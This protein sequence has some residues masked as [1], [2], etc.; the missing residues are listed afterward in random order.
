LTE[1]DQQKSNVTKSY[2]VAAL[3]ILI[4]FL[5]AAWYANTQ[6]ESHFQSRLNDIQLLQL[7]KQQL[8]QQEAERK[9]ELA[10]DL[11][12]ADPT[13][14]Q[15]L[16]QA[17]ERY[18][19]QGPK[20]DLSAIRQ[21]L[22]P[23]LNGYW[24]KVTLYGAS[25][26]HLHLA[27][28]AF[29]LLRAHRPERHSDSLIN[30]R[31]LVMH[32][33]TSGT[34]VTGTELGRHGLSL[35]A[36]VPVF[37]SRHEV[38]AA[39]ELGFD[40]QSVFAARQQ[41]YAASGVSTDNLVKE[42]RQST[43]LLVKPTMTIALHDD[44]KA[45]WLTSRLWHSPTQSDMLQFWLN[46]QLIPENVSSP[47][48]LIL[49]FNERIYA[50]SLLPWPVWGQNN[51][52]NGQVVSLSWHDISAQVNTQQ[53]TDKIIWL[54]WLAACFSMLFLAVLLITFLRR[55]ARREVSQQQKLVKQS[56]Q[57]LS[58][59][60]Q[61]SPLPILLNRFSD[62]AFVESNPAME[63]LTGYSLAEIKQL[64]YWDLTPEH[65]AAAEQE[66]LK[67]LTEYGRYGPYIKQYRHK[68]GELIDIE[69]N[70]VLFSDDR[71]EKFIWTIIKDIREIK[72]IEKLK[73]D[74]VSTVSHELRTPLTSISGSLGLVLGGAGG[75]LSPK[76]EKL[77]GIAHK[78]SQRL[79][80]LINDL[81]DIEKLVAGKMRFDEV[82]VALPGILQDA[83]EQHQ[84][85]AQQHNVTLTLNPVPDVLLW[86][87]AARVQQV[88]AN[89]LSNAVKFSPPQAT[90]SVGA[91]VHGQMVKIWVQDQGP[92]IALADQGQLFKRF[93]QL[94]H[95]DNQAKTGTGL[96]LAISREIA[97]QSAGDIGVNSVSGEGATFWLEL[98]IHQTLVHPG[99]HEAILVIEDDADTAMVL[100]EFLQ[101]QHYIA[102][103]AP[104]S[105]T[106]WQRLAEKDYA[107]ITL[108]LKLDEESGAD[109]FLRL[110]DNPATANLP[111]L[112][113]SAFIEQGKL[114]L[115]A[116]ANA[117]D[118]LEKPVTPE[119]LSVKLG[120]LLTELPYANRHQRILHVED[121]NDIIT[122]M[123]L[124][125]ANLCEYHA[126]SSLEQAKKMLQQQQF[127]LILLDLGLPDGNG[128]SL[129]HDITDCQGDIPV[130]IFSA[131]DLSV[132]NKQK[133][134]A[135]FS[136]SRINTE[137]L[138][139]YLKNILD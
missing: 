18:Q 67:A 6:R 19:Q 114:Q 125:L 124:Q 35:R 25:Q 74:F 122:I 78:N 96:G 86:V 77:L 135:V 54:I 56:E 61:L 66:Q 92:G 50:V 94:K 21:Q 115:A 17:V 47:Q 22:L 37:N 108:D 7:T 89:F 26:L 131:Q 90:V 42:A 5:L 118:W 70:G 33:L 3:M 95:E 43:I 59:L 99:L 139:K 130:V 39:V 85:F 27:P 31:P 119:L 91:E 4:T 72:R 28:D 23:I 11:I 58:A 88:L 103:W 10:V 113:I 63:K 106:A 36:V 29:T 109:F 52:Q 71:D 34:R 69:L 75:A 60:Y 14:Q 1:S 82:A 98:P 20:A 55:Q 12:A 38:Q 105:A 57:K 110:R 79:N 101:T 2:I 44:V 68:N 107:A 76:A 83:L 80:L 116:I 127:D 48:Q 121:D 41:Y 133:V 112:V 102:D 138:A 65:Y 73:D 16:L 30:I 128:M 51:Q 126:A 24:Q 87:D 134:R 97:L 93:S 123:R 111:V 136:K 100:C 13:L 132:E 120:R 46:N 32:S 81:L 129:L 117:L 64:S 9:L 53:R 15:L 40:L 49:E 45:K 84:P 104:D 62:G 137:I 8:L